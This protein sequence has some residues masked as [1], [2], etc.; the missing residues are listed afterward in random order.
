M[1]AAP[2]QSEMTYV[3]ETINCS[4]P[5]PFHVAVHCIRVLFRLPL[6]V[7]DP[8]VFSSRTRETHNRFVTADGTCISRAGLI[9]E[10]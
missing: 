10:A 1:S 9:C 2:D 6:Y 8:R 3:N 5:D 4:M 7:T